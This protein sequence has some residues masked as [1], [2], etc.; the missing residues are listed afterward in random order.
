M[1]VKKPAPKPAVKKYTNYGK[2][3]SLSRL[4]SYTDRLLGTYKYTKYASYPPHKRDA[5]IE[6]REA[7]P[8]IEERDAPELEKRGDAPS[9]QDYGDYPQTYSDY[10]E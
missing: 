9:Y 5:E 8:E 3:S 7:A 2:P 1:V 4:V 6:E 10:G